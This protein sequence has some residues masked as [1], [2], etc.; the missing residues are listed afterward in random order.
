MTSA[1]TMVRDS[2]GT[3]AQIGTNV[4][5]WTAVG[6]GANCGLGGA[7]SRTELIGDSCQEHLLETVGYSMPSAKEVDRSR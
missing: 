2:V 7:S 5:H 1:G 6:M 3:L 4:S